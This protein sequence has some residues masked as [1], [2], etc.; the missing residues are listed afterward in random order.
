MIILAHKN[1]ETLSKV[2]YKGKDLSPQ[3]SKENL[4]KIIFQISSLYDDKLLVWCEE[5]FLSSINYEGLNAIFHHKLIMASYDLGASEKIP[6]AIGYVEESPFIDVQENVLYPT[7]KM[8]TD[9]GGI[10]TSVINKI[11][12]YAEKNYSF[13]YFLNSISKKSQL[14]GLLCYSAPKLIYDNASLRSSFPQQKISRTLLFRFVKQH[15]NLKWIF[16]LFIS[17]LFYEKKF[18]GLALFKSIVY[19]RKKL[20]ENIFEQISVVSSKRIDS[21]STIDVLIP[22]LNRKKSLYNFLKD[23]SDQE[24]LPT[25][26]IIIEQDEVNEK[27]TLDYLKNN[28]WPFNVEHIFTRQTGACNARNLG[29]DLSTSDWVFFGDDDVRID[30]TF[31][32]KLI[33]NVKYYG[34]E[35]AQFSCLR[36]G[37]TNLI[38]NVIQSTIFGSGNSIVK[39]EN[40]GKLKFLQAFEF[41]YGEDLDF[42]M[43]LRKKGVDILF[44][45]EPI[46][47]HLKLSTGG[48]RSEFSYPWQHEKDQPKPAPSV[49]LYKL[50]HLTKEQILGY[51]NFFFITNLKNR[52]FNLFK[53]QKA[54]NK[55]I[56][57]SKSL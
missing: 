18:T 56:W 28:N 17:F 41:G 13:F 48:F 52:R 23:L 40:I 46:M 54:W 22:T 24:L 55:S 45:P 47:S 10:N 29:L 4:T 35:A 37:E 31:L 7:W 2:L 12:S 26:V 53:L 34:A 57:W 19:R 16:L 42:G 33:Q 15:Y 49:M 44:F 1:G 6:D 30:E 9:I 25:S 51:K 27:T 8:S 11:R 50:K 20:K 32:E 43:Q 21:P 38:S 39:R 36:D 5:S 3:F 14:K